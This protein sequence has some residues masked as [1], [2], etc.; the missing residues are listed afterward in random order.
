M[1]ASL[2][3]RVDEQQRRL[4]RERVRALLDDGAR[5]AVVLADDD[6][7]AA[8]DAGRREVG[9]RV[10]GDVGADDRLPGDRAAQRVVDRC[11]EHRRGRRLVRARLDVHAELGQIVLRLHEHVEEM[12]DRRA[13]VAADVRARPIAAAPW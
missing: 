6:Q 11:A 3:A 9:Q 7:R 5:L 8:R 10:G 12:R 1:C 2:G 4:E 13:L